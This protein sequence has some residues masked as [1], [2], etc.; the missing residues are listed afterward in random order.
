LYK[1]INNRAS[2]ASIRKWIETKHI[3]ADGVQLR[4][5]IRRRKAESNLYF[6]K[7]NNLN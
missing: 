4:G 3:T 5:L 6:K 1:L 2:E 7:Y